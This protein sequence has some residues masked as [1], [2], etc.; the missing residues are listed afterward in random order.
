MPNVQF[1]NI[2]IL[3]FTMTEKRLEIRNEHRE[4]ER[5]SVVEKLS[6]MFR[7]LCRFR[8][9]FSCFSLSK[10][11]HTHT[12]T[13]KFSEVVAVHAFKCMLTVFAMNKF[14]LIQFLCYVINPQWVFMCVDRQIDR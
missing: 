12:L 7:I 3:A 14:K 11:P 6:M 13:C 4:K 8:C 2:Q 1:E 5:E 9:V 10:S